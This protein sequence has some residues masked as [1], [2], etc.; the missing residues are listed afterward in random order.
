MFSSE[1][2]VDIDTPDGKHI[3]GWF[4]KGYVSLNGKLNGNS[5]VS[6]RFR[7]E[8]IEEDEKTVLLRISH[9]SQQLLQGYPSVRVPRDFILPA[10]NPQK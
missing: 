1:V 8:V 4:D 7:A 5:E 10:E 9:S 6:G 3:S 2:C